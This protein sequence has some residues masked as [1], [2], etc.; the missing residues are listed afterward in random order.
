[1]NDDTAQKR[2]GRALERLRRILVNRGVAVSAAGLGILVSANASP[3]LPASTQALLNRAPGSSMILSGRPDVFLKSAS[4]AMTLKK[5]KIGILAT[6]LF[7]GG[8][9]GVSL[10]VTYESGEKVAP[11]VRGDT[12]MH[13]LTDL[14]G[15]AENHRGNQILSAL[16]LVTPERARRARALTDCINAVGAFDR[17]CQ[18]AYG[19]ESSQA[20]LWG[21]EQPVLFKLQFGQENLATAHEEITGD[22]AVVNISRGGGVVQF[23][24][25]QKVGG[26]WRIHEEAVDDI[27]NESEADR[28]IRMG[29]LLESMTKRVES[30]GFKSAQ[31]AMSQLASK[32]EEIPPVQ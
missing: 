2:V 6:L 13:L 28:L 3:S 29:A 1:M 12:P 30:G 5:L 8:A 25:F 7:L 19:R 9:G 11:R 10:F 18:R 14:A 31:E 24:R 22:D 27:V 21:V 17:S 4:R 26:V 20:A 32:V 16:N 15:A 23:I